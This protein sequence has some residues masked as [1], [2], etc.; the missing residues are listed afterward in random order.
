LG[1]SGGVGSCRR[2]G[3]WEAEAH[4]TEGIDL[5][6][7]LLP[8]NFA[9]VICKEWGSE[10]LEQRIDARLALKGAAGVYGEGNGVSGGSPVRQTGPTG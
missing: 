9:S 8:E 10:G 5:P 3:P 2:C 7:Q 4:A 1:L 6:N